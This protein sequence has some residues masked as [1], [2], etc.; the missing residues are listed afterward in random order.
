MVHSLNSKK[1]TSDDTESTKLATKFSKR[2]SYTRTCFVFICLIL[3]YLFPIVQANLVNIFKYPSTFR[4]Q[5]IIVVHTFLVLLR[6]Q[7]C[8]IA[9]SFKMDNQRD[10]VVL[11]EPSQPPEKF[12]TVVTF[13]PTPVGATSKKSISLKVRWRLRNLNTPTRLTILRTIAK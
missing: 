6:K 2:K 7:T 8:Q 5:R 9:S 1:L 12:A 10:E 4:N 11:Q 3:C 13:E